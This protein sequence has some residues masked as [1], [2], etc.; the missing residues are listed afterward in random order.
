MTD[1]ERAFGQAFVSKAVG[2]RSVSG[3]LMMH[4]GT[5]GAGKRWPGENAKNILLM[6]AARG[7]HCFL[8]DVQGITAVSGVYPEGVTLVHGLSH[9]GVASVMAACNVILCVDNHIFNSG[10]FMRKAVVPLFGFRPDYYA[11]VVTKPGCAHRFGSAYT[12]D[13]CAVFEAIET[14]KLIVSQDVDENCDLSEIKTF[15]I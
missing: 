12:P 9:S 2:G 6:A 3:L 4:L 11:K 13:P 7:Y 1:D 10:K 14:E 15:E 5:D 8:L